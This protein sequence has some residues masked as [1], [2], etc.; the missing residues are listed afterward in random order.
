[1][2]IVLGNDTITGLGVGG[3]P[4]GTINAADLAAGAARANF[5]AGAVLQVV[6]GQRTD[7]FSMSISNA[8]FTEIPSFSAIITPSSTSSKIHVFALI[9]ASYNN[10]HFSIRLKRSGTVFGTGTGSGDSNYSSGMGSVSVG[11][12]TNGTRPIPFQWLDAPAT[13]SAVTYTVDIRADLGG[14]MY[15]N[16]TVSGSGNGAQTPST[17][18]LMEIAA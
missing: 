17:I 14:T 18:I 1:M 5:G 10:D 15:I 12:N 16:R 7:G 4:D 13:T 2:P 9:G 6:Q 8:T 3:L 11:G